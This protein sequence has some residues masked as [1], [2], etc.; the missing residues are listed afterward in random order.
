MSVPNTDT[1]ALSDVV[2]EIGLTSPESLQHCFDNAISW[3]F[4]PAYSGSK[5]RLSN[6]R[7]YGR[8]QTVIHTTYGKSIYN[9]GT[10]TWSSIRDAVSGILTSDHKP[11]VDFL[12]A[13]YWVSRMFLQF[14]LSDIPSGAEIISAILEIEQDAFYGTANINVIRGTFGN[15][16]ILESDFDS[17]VWGDIFFNSQITFTNC[18]NTIRKWTATGAQL[19]LIDNYFGT[20]LKFVLIEYAHDFLDSAPTDKEGYEFF[21]SGECLTGCICLPQLTIIYK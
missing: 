10:G 2:P 8:N 20:Y 6:F 15:T 11:F 3:K 13:K 18:V 17:L 5:D 16:G 4:D 21:Y 19:N 14:D 7:N 12:A 1:F 9:T